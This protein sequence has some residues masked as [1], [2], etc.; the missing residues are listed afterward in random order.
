MGVGWGRF[1]PL[2]SEGWVE[3]I[4]VSKGWVKIFFC[5]EMFSLR[6]QPQP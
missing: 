6:A 1:P 4:F 2:H 3:D 5:L